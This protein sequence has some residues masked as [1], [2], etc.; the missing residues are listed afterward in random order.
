[1]GEKKDGKKVWG[2]SNYEE[3]ERWS[4]AE[5]T[6]EDAIKAAH[7]AHGRNSTVYVREGIQPYNGYQFLP[8][9]EFILEHASNTAFEEVGEVAEEWPDVDDHG[10]KELEGFLQEWASK[11][12]PTTF[13]FATGK[14]EKIEP[15]LTGEWICSD[16]WRS[17]H[18]K[19]ATNVVELVVRCDGC[20]RVM[21]GLQLEKSDAG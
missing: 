8:S 18:H 19:G 13:W 9:V 14:P 17:E 16:C 21:S 11:Y 15:E 12:L 2:F 3:D 5:A 7:A 6:R 4:G 10:V 1:M 20:D